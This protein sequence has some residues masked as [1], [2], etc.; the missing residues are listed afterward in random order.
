MAAYIVFMKEREHDEKA[1]E[2]YSKA[3]PASFAGHQPKPLAI[4]GKVESLEG[5]PLMGAVVIEFPTFEAAK[6]WYES[7]KY[8]DARKHR[9]QGADYRAFIVEGT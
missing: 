4:Y 2:A 5:P 6:A 1:L 9:F 3:V 8:Q 7:D